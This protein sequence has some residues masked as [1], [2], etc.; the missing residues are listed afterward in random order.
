MATLEIERSLSPLTIDDLKE[1]YSG[2][3]NRLNEYF[4]NGKCKK[5]QRYYEINNPLAVALCQGAAMHYHDKINGIKDFDV[6]F[7]YAFNQKHLPYRTYWNWDYTNPKFGTHPLIPGYKGRKVDV[8]VRSIKNYSE[9]D[10]VSTI[11]QFL[12]H[13]NT[14]SSNELAKKGVVLLFPESLLGK[15]VWYKQ[16]LL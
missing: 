2:S 10:P 4:I 16:R 9:G 11:H 7:F 8:L 3:M 15:T 6:W 5:W 1:L 12:Q 13:E 14:T